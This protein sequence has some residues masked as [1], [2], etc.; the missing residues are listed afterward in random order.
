MLEVLKDQSARLSTRLDSEKMSPEAIIDVLKYYD[1]LNPNEQVLSDELAT[2]PALSRDLLFNQVIQ[3]KISYPGLARSERVYGRVYA[4]F[5]IDERGQVQNIVLLSPENVGFGFDYAVKQA[6]KK[7]PV[8]S[9]EYAGKYALP[10]AFTFTN[11][12]KN[13]TVQVPVNRLPADRLAERIELEEITVSVPVGESFTQ[14]PEGRE[15]WGYYK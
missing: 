8:L 9:P 2:K 12:S 3:N 13:K 6:L 7:L 5:E 10:V 15:V 4:G 14:R 11:P 1:T